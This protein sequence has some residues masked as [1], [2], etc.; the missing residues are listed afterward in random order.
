MK[1]TAGKR[2]FGGASGSEVVGG[3]DPESTSFLESIVHRAAG[4]DVVGNPGR[5]AIGQGIGGALGEILVQQIVDGRVEAQVLGCAEGTAQAE[6]VI[7]LQI[8]CRVEQLLVRPAEVLV[9]LQEALPL[10]AI[11]T[12][13][14]DTGLGSGI[15]SQA[16][17]DQVFR[18]GG[19]RRA[20]V[21]AALLLAVGVGVVGANA[22][23]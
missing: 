6:H 5:V 20:L 23:A 12:L 1:A 22:P 4:L 9:V 19:E 3:R 7:G 8:A 21:L 18:G 14:P 2:A 17:G 10:T 15:P 13:Q 11:L 16:G